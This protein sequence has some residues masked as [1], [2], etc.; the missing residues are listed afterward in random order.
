MWYE[1]RRLQTGDLPEVTDIYNAAC[2]DRESTQGTRPWS[3][4]EMNQFL[5]ALRPSFVSYTCI[6]KGGVVGWA[7]LTPHHINEGVRQTAEM[8][9]FV[10]GA[11]RRKGVG[12]A[13]AHAVLSQQSTAN[14]HCILA[15]TFADAPNV[16]SFA[17][18]RCSLSVAGCLPGAFSDKGNNYDILVLQR[19]IVP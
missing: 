13:L 18:R 19:L 11:F 12:S 3:V 1:L 10:Q 6:S 16:I 8:S 9:L 14:L 2:R 15:M 4:A 7:A 17:Q 5:F